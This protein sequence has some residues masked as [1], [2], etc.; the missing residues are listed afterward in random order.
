MLNKLFTSGAGIGLIQGT[1]AIPQS[2]DY[3]EIVKA[4]TQLVIAIVTVIMLLKQNKNK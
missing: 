1:E 2:L 4:I 3:S